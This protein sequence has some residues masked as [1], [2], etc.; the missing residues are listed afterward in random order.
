MG[1]GNI[2][3]RESSSSSQERSGTYISLFVVIV[4]FDFIFIYT[5]SFEFIIMCLFSGHNGLSAAIGVA[6]WGVA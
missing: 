6:S 1:K 4:S 3:R 2:S 5:G